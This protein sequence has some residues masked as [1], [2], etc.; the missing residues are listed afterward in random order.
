MCIASAH[1][2]YKGFVLKGKKLN[3]LEFP[4]PE[5]RR[6]VSR[7]KQTENLCIFQVP[8]PSHVLYWTNPKVNAGCDMHI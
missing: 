4:E 2:K 8:V 1:R 5:R 7:H 6:D 3:P